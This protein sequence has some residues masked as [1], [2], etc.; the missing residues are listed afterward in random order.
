MPHILRGDNN[1][2][3]GMCLILHVDMVIAGGLGWERLALLPSNAGLGL[4][5]RTCHHSCGAFYLSLRGCA[6]M[7]GN[8]EA[9]SSRYPEK[10][11]RPEKAAAT[12][13][14]KK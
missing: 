2:G 10:K 3:R 7:A 11:S 4:P 12:K 5:T 13:E 14:I 8:S 1:D 9:H 6:I